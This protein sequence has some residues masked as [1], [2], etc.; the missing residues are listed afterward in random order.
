MATTHFIAPRLWF[1]QLAEAAT[2]FSTSI[3]PRSRIRAVS[4]YRE[5]GQ[6]VHGRPPGS[7]MTEEFS[8]IAQPRPR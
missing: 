3:F 4:R 2:E 7:V 8:L 1:E 6:G 5:A